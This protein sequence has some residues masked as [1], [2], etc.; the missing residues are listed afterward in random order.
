MEAVKRKY[1]GNFSAVTPNG[2]NFS[3]V[4]GFSF[5]GGSVNEHLKLGV[6]C[7]AQLHVSVP[8]RTANNLFFDG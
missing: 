6:N 1:G 7:G 4:S 2:G 5:F 3:V 8:E